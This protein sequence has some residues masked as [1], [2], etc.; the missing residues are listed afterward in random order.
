MGLMI[1]AA[2]T[3]YGVGKTFFWPTMLGVVAEQFPKGGALTLNAT[4]AMGMMGVGVIGA[5]FLGAIQDKAVD[6]YLVDKNPDLH[7]K[8][9]EREEGIFGEYYGVEASKVQSLPEDQQEV[10]N[11]AVDDA[12]KNALAVVAIFPGI[13]FVCYLILI[14]YFRSKGGYDAEV[15][16]GHGSHEGEYDEGQ[17]GPVDQ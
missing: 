7:S 8:V 14:L 17:V 5:V 10:V 9:M 16:T 11:T 1:L 12:K 13:M 2:A 15:L 6:D 4:G 3:V